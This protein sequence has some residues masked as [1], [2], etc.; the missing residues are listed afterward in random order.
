[1]SVPVDF[2][3]GTSEPSAYRT[4]IN[5]AC[6]ND[7]LQPN[8][9]WSS[10]EQQDN[11]NSMAVYG[12]NEDNSKKGFHYLNKTNSFSLAYVRAVFAY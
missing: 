10:S 11:S 12:F 4:A 8:E 7:A 2:P 6:G 9:Y 1:M 5:T 3:H